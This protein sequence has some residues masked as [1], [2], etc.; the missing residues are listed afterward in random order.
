M[1]TSQ[2]NENTS[3]CH[4]SKLKRELFFVRYCINLETTNEETVA[5]GQPSI[6]QQSSTKR[7]PTREHRLPCFEDYFYIVC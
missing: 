2:Q 7:Y 5:A 4:K 1:L 3:L 6:N